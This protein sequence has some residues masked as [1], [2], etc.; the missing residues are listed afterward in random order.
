[1]P[2]GLATAEGETIS[3]DATEQEFAAAMAAPSADDP[4]APGPPDL[5]PVDPDAPWGRTAA[6]E[7]KRKPGRP[8]KDRPRTVPGS[9]VSKPAA[10]QKG[11]KPAA[12]PGP[13]RDYS[14]GLGEF[15]QLIWMALAGLPIPWEETRIRCRVQAAVLKENQAGVVSGVNIMAQHNKVVRWGVEKLTMGQ[16]GWIFPAAL[17]L[18]PFAVQT[19]ML[20]RVPV[21][22]DMQQMAAGVEDEFGEV[23]SSILKQMGLVDEEPGDAEQ[24]AAA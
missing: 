4:E 2:E 18:M 7:P 11:G 15:T 21:N 9:S 3:F 24:P 20:W 1:M 8:R 10:P 13:A 12:E 6:G 17:A 19:N 5:P 14:E 16:A 23:F 22:G